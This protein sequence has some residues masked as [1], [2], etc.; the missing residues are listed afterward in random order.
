LAKDPAERYPSAATLRQALSE[1]ESAGN[2]T[3]GDAARWW[4]AHGQTDLQAEELA[5]SVI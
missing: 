4:R 3:D 5:A 2:W 1:C